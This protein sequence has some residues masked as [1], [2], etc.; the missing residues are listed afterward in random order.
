MK[1]A[2][3]WKLLERFGVQGVQFVLQIVLA[4]I[5]SPDDYGV[6]AIMVIFTTIANVFI[7]TGFNTALIQNKDVTEEDYSTVLWITLGIAGILYGVIFFTAPAIGGFYS[8]PELITP[9]R[10]LALMLFPGALNSIQLA[11]V[12]REMDFKK[13][14]YSNVGAIIVS[15]VAGIAV[16]V[17]G[18]G[19][20]ALVIQT[21]LNIFTATVVMLFTA[22]I[23]IYFKINFNRA[24]VLFSFGWKLLVSAVIDTLYQNLQSLVIGKK[25]NSE[26]LGYHNRG[27]Q[28]PQF[29]ITSISGAIQSVMLPALSEKQDKKDELKHMMRNA[30]ALSSY[31]IFPM[32][33]GL[34]GVAT[35]FVKL[36]LTDK[37]LPCVPYLQIYC[38]SFIFYPINACN[39]QA[40]NAIG[41]SD[42]FL[43]IEIIKKIYGVIA[44]IIAICFF[45]SPIA[46]ALSAVITTVISCFV[47]AAPNKKLISYSYME[48]IQ[49]I[50]P[51]FVISVIMFL[52]V[53]AVEL[54][55]LGDFVTL[56]LQIILGIALYLLM[57]IIFR[58]K[59]FV[60]LLSIAKNFKTS[61]FKNN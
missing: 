60:Q 47:N 6:L 52:A 42:W 34:A 19:L 24:K 5:L 54:L 7:Q 3:I 57:S 38:F 51:S 21:M 59:P 41:R 15:G 13:V 53:W 17:L 31:V 4:R 61:L 30:V 32:A 16:A 48:Q 44:L 18:G 35:S 10:V 27:L 46:I 33:L 43:K 26:T 50:L 11:K 37:W 25:Y 28:F 58:V 12:S 14:F 36:V 40:I 23:K 1:K 9:L 49:D 8:K 2:L 39:L 20:W 55:G 56:I 45:E 22:K 29:L